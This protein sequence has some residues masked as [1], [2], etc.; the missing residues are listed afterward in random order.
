M[1]RVGVKTDAVP[2]TYGDFPDREQAQEFI[3]R[4]QRATDE[5]L[6]MES[7]YTGLFTFRPSAV[8]SIRMWEMNE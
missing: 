5:F 1:F 7:S 3:H 8:I 2:E 4:I 6:T